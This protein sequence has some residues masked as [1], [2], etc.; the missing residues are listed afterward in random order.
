M[1]L[2]RFATIACLAMLTF[3]TLVGCGSKGDADQ[4]TA[5]INGE[6]DKTEATA[7]S[8]QTA[9][10]KATLDREHPVVVIDT[11]LGS[12]TVRLDAKKANLT[13]ENF[14]TYAASGHYNQTIFHQVF[15]GQAIVGGAYQADLTEKALPAPTPPPLRNEAHKALKNRR[16]TI[17]MVR[18]QD[19]IDSATCQFFFNVADNDAFDHKDGTP[20][21]YGY[22][23]FGEVTDGMA[24]IDK[25]ANLP[26]EDSGQLDRKPVQT[27]AIKSVRRAK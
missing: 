22:C 14:L 2:N 20:E 11:S 16:G 23:A 13:V 27:V 18:A 15:K 21:N 24:V 12:I 1:Q 9:K 7:G 26:T 25:I 10:D 17:A 4:P 5:A 3:P 6:G 8:S 19:A